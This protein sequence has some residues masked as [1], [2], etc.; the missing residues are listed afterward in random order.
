MWARAGLIRTGT[1]LWEAHNRL[2]GLEPDLRRSIE[3]RVAFDVARLVVAAALRR[4][5]SRGGHYRADYPEPD[6]FQV[7]RTLVEPP[8]VET[9]VPVGV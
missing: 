3:G 4:S 6:P 5:E 2:L 9:A 7:S 1:G 8:P